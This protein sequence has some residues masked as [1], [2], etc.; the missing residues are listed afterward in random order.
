MKPIIPPKYLV[1]LVVS[2]CSLNLLHAL[3]PWAS[4]I[5]VENIDNVISHYID[6][7]QKNTKIDLSSKIFHLEDEKHVEILVYIDGSKFT[8][9]D[10]Q[11]IQQLAEILESNNQTGAFEL[12]SLR[13]EIK[14]L[15]QYQNNLIV[16]KKSESLAKALLAQQ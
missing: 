2:N 12:G 1:G 11:Y 3:E 9:Q 8:N 4:K 6:S 7:E 14:A 5:Y 16:C 13:L 15:T 10:Y